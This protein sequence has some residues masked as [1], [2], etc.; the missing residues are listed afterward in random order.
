MFG[1]GD[2][3]KRTRGPGIEPVIALTA[4][5]EA[6]LL[7]RRSDVVDSTTRRVQFTPSMARSP[8][9]F[10]SRTRGSPARSVGN[11]P[12][13]ENGGRTSQTSAGE[14]YGQCVARCWAGYGDC[15]LGCAGLL[16][17]YPRKWLGVNPLQCAALC[18]LAWSPCFARC[19]LRRWLTPPTDDCTDK[20]VQS[21]G[22]CGWYDESC[23]AGMTCRANVY[24]SK[25]RD[26][27]CPRDRPCKMVVHVNDKCYCS[28][29]PQPFDIIPDQCGPCAQKEA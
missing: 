5:G 6:Y 20:D 16:P 19:S 29:E 14:S 9:R 8:A 23:G 26:E 12:A 24:R 21:W 4:D 1:N 17:P 28:K 2:S 27:R 13:G 7:A 3:H 11:H 22:N 25:L 10:Q 15:V 18:W